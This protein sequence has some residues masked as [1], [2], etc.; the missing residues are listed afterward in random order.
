M[1]I[2]KNCL[3]CKKQYFAEDSVHSKN[4]I[5]KFCSHKCTGIAFR[6][7]KIKIKC[8]FCKR[9]KYDYPYKKNSRFCSRSCAGKFNYPSKLANASKAH[10]FGNTFCKGK[11]PINK[12]KKFP[13]F[14]GENNPNYVKPIKMTCLN[15]NNLFFKKPWELRGSGSNRKFCTRACLLKH[16]EKIGHYKVFFKLKASPTKPEKKLIKIIEKH[17]LP[18]KFTGNKIFW[19]G[20]LNPDFIHTKGEKTALEVFGSYWHDPKKRKGLL[21]YSTVEGRKKIFAENG[22]KCIIFWD[23]EVKENI[24]LERLFQKA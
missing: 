11:I 20:N 4:R 16:Y 2:K 22:W 12:G 19:V 18:Y 8:L 1:I 10:L 9:E 23:Y 7:L 6:K 15:C 5:R 13:E 17:K 24:V 3:V 14:S 21:P